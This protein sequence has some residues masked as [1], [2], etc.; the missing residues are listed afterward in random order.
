MNWR[1]PGGKKFVTNN[2]DIIKPWDV[3]SKSFSQIFW[4]LYLDVSS[5]TFRFEKLDTVLNV[6]NIEITKL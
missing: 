5:N 3:F 4:S 2:S 1:R 6:S